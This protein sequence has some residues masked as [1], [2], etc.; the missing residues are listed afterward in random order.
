MKN[1]SLTCSDCPRFYPILTIKKI[2]NPNKFYAFPILGFLVKIIMIL[3]LALILVIFSITWVFIGF[4]NS[5]VV[6]IT[7]KYWPTAY[8][9][10]KTFITLTV[11]VYLFMLGLTDKYP[12]FNFTIPNDYKLEIPHPQHPDR[13]LSIPF[14]GGFIRVFILIPYFIFEQVITN[15]GYFASLIS[16]APVL[17]KGFYPESTFEMARDSIRV[18]QASTIYLFGLSDKYP[19][20]YIS[21]NHK[22][23]KIFLI[24]MGILL[25]FAN[26]TTYQAPY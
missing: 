2:V 1:Y 18:N 4:I 26:R 19:S 22:R 23:I 9:F 25:S 5:F 8:D 13:L 21:L 7:G 16:F 15:A 17:F 12:G 24:I 14:L 11:K 10:N 20:F 3:P 6:T